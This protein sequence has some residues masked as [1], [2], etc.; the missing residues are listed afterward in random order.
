M[1]IKD[2]IKSYS[3]WNTNQTEGFLNIAITTH[4]N[5]KLLKVLY[6]NSPKWNGTYNGKLLPSSDYWFFAIISPKK[7][8]KGHFSLKR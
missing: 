2:K 3:I 8:I 7:T 6:P 4:S 1:S 5:G